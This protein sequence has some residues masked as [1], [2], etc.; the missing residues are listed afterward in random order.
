LDL[1]NTFDAAV[2]AAAT[3]AFWCQCWLGEVCVD[4]FF[5]PT[6]HASCATQQKMG[7]MLQTLGFILSGHPQQ[8]LVLMERKLGGLTLTAA[9]AWSGP[10]KII[11]WSTP[12]FLQ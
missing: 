5:N 4:S 1:N 7:W 6:I 10:S 11:G 9:A 2:F 12:M 3:V 8:K